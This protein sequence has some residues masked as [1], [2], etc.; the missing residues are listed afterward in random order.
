MCRA[1]GSI[2]FK[3][4]PVHP[5]NFKTWATCTWA[6]SFGGQPARP[7][8]MRGMATDCMPLAAACVSTDWMALAS[9]G[10]SN[11][12]LPASG[13]LLKQQATL[14]PRTNTA[15]ITSSRINKTA[16]FGCQASDCAYDGQKSLLTLPR[17]ITAVRNKHS[18]GD[19][20]MGT[21]TGP[22]CQRNSS[23]SLVH[24]SSSL[25]PIYVYALPATKEPG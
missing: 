23:V 21:A 13:T 25:L 18:A 9:R 2:T 8:P 16:R 20:T 4:T 22:G 15:C 7:A 14:C 19:C 10:T 5:A 24:S 11:C 17:G 3:G 12:W 1:T 6:A